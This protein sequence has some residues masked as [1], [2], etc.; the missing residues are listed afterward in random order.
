MNAKATLFTVAMVLVAATSVAGPPAPKY[1]YI[2]FSATCNPDDE[3]TR[4]TLKVV[5]NV[6]E[7]CPSELDRDALV[8]SMALVWAGI[9]YELCGEGALLYGPKFYSFPTLR[10]AQG[11]RERTLDNPMFDVKGT[12]SFQGPT[13]C[14]GL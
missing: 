10:H 11:A 2:D 4:F 14:S 6:V 5:S 1:G 3:E 13:F 9:S 7:Y 8:K 12:V